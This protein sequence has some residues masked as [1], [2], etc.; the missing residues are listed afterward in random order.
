MSVAWQFGALRTFGYD[1]IVCDPPWD[2]EL[3]SEAGEG[4]SAKA[5]Y[6]T[7]PLAEI[8]ALRVGDL[9]RGDCLLLLWCCEWI[10][11]VARQRVLDAWGF[12]YKTS[13]VWRKTTKRGKVRMGPGYRARTM[14]EPVIVATVGNPQHKAFPSVFD[15]VAREHSRKPDEFYGLVE[16]S[17]PSAVRADLFARQP[18][19][20]W[21]VW[22]NEAEKFAPADREAA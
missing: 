9:A 21:S 7:M 3:Y 15:G 17:A 20:G 2:F 22:G 6:Q 13:I 12:T 5:H 1:V 11:P 8:E 16:A 18:R 4:K 14:H 10:P 19:E